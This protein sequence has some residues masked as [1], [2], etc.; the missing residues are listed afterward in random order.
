MK[1]DLE[2]S[3][4]L[5]DQYITQ[6]SPKSGLQPNVNVEGGEYIKTP[7]GSVLEVWGNKH[8]KGGVNLLVPNMTAVLSDTK[9]LT[10]KKSDVKKL[11]NEY[12]L[13]GTKTSNTYS[14]VLDMYS[15]K[16]GRTKVINELKEYYKQLE[17]QL[18]NTKDKNTKDNVN[19]PYISS[20]IDELT[21]KKAEQD[22]L[23]EN[24][25]NE[26]FA[27]Q[28]KQKPDKEVPQDYQPI[29][30]EYNTPEDTT[31][32]EMVRTA[33]EDSLTPL[34]SFE[35]GGYVNTIKDLSSKYNWTERKT[36]DFLKS[37]NILPKY[38]GGGLIVEYGQNAFKGAPTGLQSASTNAY[39]KIDANQAIKDLYLQFPTILSNEKYKNLISF[40]DGMPK[41]KQGV[42]LNKKNQLIGD[43]QNDMNNQMKKSAERIVNDQ[44]GLFSQDQIQTA[45][46]YLDEETFVPQGT[47][48]SRAID[49]MLGEFTSRRTSL[50]LSLVNP[51][52]LQKLQSKGIYSLKQLQNSPEALQELSLETQANVRR[53]GEDIPEEVDYR[54][55]VYNTPEQKGEVVQDTD[56]KIEE[57]NKLP[58]VGNGTKPPPGNDNI[59]QLRVPQQYWTPDQSIPMPFALAP[60]TLEQL[61]FS[62][63][64]PTRVGIEDNLNRIAASR[65]FIAGQLQNLTGSQ[66]AALLANVVATSQQ[67]ETDAI[68][69]ASQINA[70]NVT[71]ADQYNAS[72]AD[73]EE[74]TNAQQ[75]L[76]YEQRV[77]K[78]I[79]NF[80]QNLFNY[81]MANRN[82]NLQTASN[83]LNLNRMDALFPDISIDRFGIS[84]YYNPQQQFQLQQPNAEYLQIMNLLGQGFTPP[85]NNNKNVKK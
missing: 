52:E 31:E 50:G 46:R 14:D 80:E 59:K 2:L 38:Q 24:M 30:E 7:E 47:K 85:N 35:L 66:R 82:I 11:E 61:S 68:N 5:T 21:K 64:D 48:S 26:M 62:R 10:I 36:Y 74:T 56:E 32:N 79:D 17:E 44:S 40:E 22:I 43:L 20:K 78:G 39:G 4:L 65:D 28:Q 33:V 45:Q 71:M 18:K 8:K 6:L 76:N 34:E 77:L 12:N 69:K 41:L 27:S 13:K 58:I 60:E 67:T 25:F 1:K 3:Q 73:A 29:T 72:R 53:L 51:T 84:G 83:Q 70:Q 15:R 75:R 16:I 19:I 81:M 63:L 23:M 9:D 42:S 55:S 49:N 54:I 37:R 57:G